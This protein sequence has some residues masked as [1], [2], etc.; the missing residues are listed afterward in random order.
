M[1]QTLGKYKFTEDRYNC[2]VNYWQI[3][4]IKIN[5]QNINEKNNIT[6]KYNQLRK[7]KM[8]IS[9]VLF[10]NVLVKK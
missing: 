4:F 1:L 6:G 9:L 2:N 8:K 10:K 7:L 3:K 5:I